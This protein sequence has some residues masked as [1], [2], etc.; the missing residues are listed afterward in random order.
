M[1]A[2][3]TGYALGVPELPD[4]EVFRRRLARN[5][6]HHRI[7]RIE[8]V[9]PTVLRDVSRQRLARALHGHELVRTRRHGKHLLV[10]IDEVG[11][12]VLHFGMTGF[13]A[14]A[15]GVEPATG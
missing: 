12:L 7:S 5:A 1:D 4:V 3:T 15:T 14:V 10:A 8:I 6:L 13:L 9:D 2:V 11:W